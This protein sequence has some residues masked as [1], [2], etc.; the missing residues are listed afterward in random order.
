MATERRQL[1]RL[2]ALFLFIATLMG[3][4]L[5]AGAPNP[6]HWKAV[7]V[8]TILVGLTLIGQGLIWSEL[9]LSNGQRRAAFTMARISAGSVMLLGLSSAVLAIPGPAS[10]PG[11]AP[12]GIQTV[13]LIALLII[14]VPTTIGSTFLVWRGLGG[15]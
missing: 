9:R 8:S 7:H 4:V 5:A 3:V 10:A 13:I 2:G 1:L 15:D 14:V 11:V 6:A 12:Q